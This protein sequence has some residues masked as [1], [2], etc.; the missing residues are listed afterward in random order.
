MTREVGLVRRVGTI[1]LEL[2]NER[3]G[4]DGKVGFDGDVGL[5][6]LI[7]GLD[8]RTELDEFDVLGVMVVLNEPGLEKELDCFEEKNGLGGLDEK[9][10]LCGLDE[11]VGLG[12]L[13]E[14][15]VSGGLDEKVGLGGLYETVGLV[16]LD[17][18][19]G[20][21]G[22]DEKACLNG[23]EVMVSLLDWLEDLGR[24]S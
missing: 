16:G 22:L 23:L 14:K 4:L 3:D 13:D 17:E 10:G 8:E 19:D 12:G 7:L 2:K 6:E 20:L 15:D 24:S 18:K 1:G 5:D 21:D 9:D 11:K